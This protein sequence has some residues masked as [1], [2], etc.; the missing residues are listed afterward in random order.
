MEWALEIILVVLLAVTLFHAVR[1]ERALGV[2]KRDRAVLEELVATFNDSTRQ[3]ESGVDRLRAAADGA[4]RQIARQIDAAKALKD[5]IAFL[6]D[7]GER[8]ADRLDALIRSARPLDRRSTTT[9]GHARRTPGADRTP[10]TAA[11]AQPGRARP[12]ESAQDGTLMPTLHA[13][14]L[15]PATIAALAAL[16]AMK[17]ISLVRAA[18]P[19]KLTAR[20]GVGQ[21]RQGG[22]ATAQPPPARPASDAAGSAL[23]KAAETRSVPPNAQCFW[24]CASAAS[25]STARDGRAERPRVGA[26]RGRKAPRCTRE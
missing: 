23:G 22:P 1:L 21:R 8:L 10:R 20:H 19:A 3:A 15:L 14:R 6:S 17:S 18:L 25:S 12:A 4:G 13:P 7:R 16:L 26:G 9:H 24:N 5:D 2:L 11:R